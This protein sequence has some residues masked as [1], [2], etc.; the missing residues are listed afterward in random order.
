ML[1]ASWGNRPGGLGEQPPTPQEEAGWLVGAEGF[2]LFQLFS[3][4]LRKYKIRE[5]SPVGS[6]SS[7]AKETFYE[8]GPEGEK[9]ACVTPAVG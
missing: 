8:W 3:F 7:W 4:C 9:R 6:C 1:P 5:Q 2:S